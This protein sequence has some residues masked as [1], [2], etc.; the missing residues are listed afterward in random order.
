MTLCTRFCNRSRG[1][2]MTAV[3]VMIAAALSTAPLQA[4]DVVGIEDCS[5]AAGIDKKAG[6]LQ[7]NVNYLHGLIRKNDAA[8]Q[9]RLRESDAKL[10]AANASLHELRGEIDRLKAALDRLE[11]RPA[12]K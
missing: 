9:A 11:K 2:A 12:A 10:A 4:Q 7:S 8:A 6:C 1:A 3:F 5:R